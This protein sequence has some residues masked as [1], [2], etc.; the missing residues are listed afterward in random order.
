[1]KKRL[2]TLISCAIL[3]LGIL[4]G[5]SSAD[6]NTSAGETKTWRIGHEEVAGGVQD[7]YAM[8]FK[9][10]VEERSNGKIEVEVYRANEIGSAT[11]YLEFVQGGLLNFALV[12][13]GSSGTTVP[14]NNIFYNHF[15]LPEDDRDV[16]EFLKT[17]ES[18]KLLNEINEENEMK[19]LDWFYQGYNAWTANNEIRKPADFKGVSI[20]TMQSPLIVASYSA[21]GANPTPMPYMEVYSGLQLKQIDAQVN[22]IFAIQEMGFYEVQKYLIQA[23]Q[24]GFISGMIANK[25]YYDKLSSQEREMLKQII[26]ELNKFIYDV[27]IELNEKD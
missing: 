5:C 1:M 27:E 26:E 16:Q 21:Y 3:S 7:Q 23:K 13:P 9:R 19:V 18:I 10:L 22:P 20:R 2:L 6:I 25:D 11:D 15:L 4:S 8:E 12:N 14:E 17:S 24:D